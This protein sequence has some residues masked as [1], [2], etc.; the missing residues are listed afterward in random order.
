MKC[1]TKLVARVMAISAVLGLVVIGAV[2]LASES[3][4]QGKSAANSFNRLLKAPSTAKNAQPAEDGIHDSQNPGTSMLQWPSEAFTGFPQSNDG[5]QVDWVNTLKEGKIAPWFEFETKS[6]EPFL[7]DLVIV[8]EVKG[9]M[10]NV[11]FPHEAH[12]QW[13]DC[14]NC[15]DEIFVPQKGGNQISMAAILLGQKCGVCHGR[16]AFPVTDCRRCHAQ[17]KTAEELRALAQ[18]SNWAKT[19]NAAGETTEKKAEPKK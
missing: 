12:T 14:S 13:L 9:S 2:S 17:P 11:V 8:R 19:S 4:A 18:K 6:T 1:C 5:N 7:F 10:P 15:H 16:V 3:S